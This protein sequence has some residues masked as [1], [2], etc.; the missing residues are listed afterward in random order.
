MFLTCL[1]RLS[2]LKRRLKYSDGEMY[3][4]EPMT[5]FSFEDR[6]SVTLTDKS[7][8]AAVFQAAPFHTVFVSGAY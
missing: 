2:S 7:R 8:T 1:R 4:G 5:S 3:T 6:Q